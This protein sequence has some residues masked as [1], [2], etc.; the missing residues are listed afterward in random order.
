MK[1]RSLK[2][3]KLNKQL[4]SHFEVEH[5]KGGMVSNNEKCHTYMKESV[6]DWCQYSAYASC[7]SPCDSLYGT[8]GCNPN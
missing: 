7:Y 2:S 8:N 4:I 6:S 5:T 3:L 1:K